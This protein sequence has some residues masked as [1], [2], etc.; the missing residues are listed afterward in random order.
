MPYIHVMTNA[1][2][3]P[4]RENSL[5]TGLGKAIERIPGKTEEWLMLDLS[6]G[7]R[8]WFRG[9]DEPCAIAEVKIF[10]SAAPEAYEAMTAEV[11]ALFS[12]EL[13]LP[14]DRVYV[15]YEECDLWGW[16]GRNF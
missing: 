16:N 8:M 10:G 9:T 4:E 14:P 5:K 6:A 11:C 3:T 1:V 12:R 13:T 7:E 2:L 15:K